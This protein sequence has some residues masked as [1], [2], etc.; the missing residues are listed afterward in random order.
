VNLVTSM[1]AESEAASTRSDDPSDESPSGAASGGSSAS[2]EGGLHGLGPLV[3]ASNAPE[4]ERLKAE[5]ES[6]IADENY[7]RAA[8]IRDKLKE[9]EG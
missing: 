7:E 3:P 2:G 5:L 1:Q 8:A 4:V 9:L 6:A